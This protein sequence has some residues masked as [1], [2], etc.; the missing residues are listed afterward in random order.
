MSLEKRNRRLIEHAEPMTGA[1]D[2]QRLAG[3]LR[4]GAA[5]TL[6][7]ARSAERSAPLAP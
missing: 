6:T 2:A 3:L 7:T 4:T 1:N 5:P